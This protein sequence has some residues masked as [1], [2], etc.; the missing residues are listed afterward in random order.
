MEIMIITM[1]FTDISPLLSG[2]PSINDPSNVSHILNTLN[3]TSYINLF[4]QSY[5]RSYRA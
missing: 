2:L 3:I 4:V 1:V 5:L